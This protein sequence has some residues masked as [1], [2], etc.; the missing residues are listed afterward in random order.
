M[1]SFEITN[2][3]TNIQY[4]Y[5]NDELIVNGNCAKDASNGNVQSISGSCYV[6]NQNEQGQFVGN[7]NGYSRDGKIKYSFSEVSLEDLDKVQAAI[8]D[9]E[10]ELLPLAAE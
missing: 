1:K 9:I 6:N 7:F 4:I 5:K 8:A 3:T 2:Q 10:E